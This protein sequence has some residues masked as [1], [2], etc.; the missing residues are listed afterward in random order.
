MPVAQDQCGLTTC[1]T[2]VNT[3]FWHNEASWGGAIY[4]DDAP[5]FCR[6]DGGAKFECTTCSF[7]NNTAWV[8]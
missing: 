4:V 8:S 1:V 5:P 2:I 6:R 3:I 7:V